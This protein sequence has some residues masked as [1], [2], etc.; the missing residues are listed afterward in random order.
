MS[1]NSSGK[2]KGTRNREYEDKRSKLLTSAGLIFLKEPT[3]KQSLRQI[4]EGV[5]VTIPTLNHYFGGRDGVISAYLEFTWQS[6]HWHLLDAAEPKGDL[7]ACIRLKLENLR[8]AFCHYGLEQLHIFGITEG[9]G[10]SS[11]GP[12]YLN[13]FLEP[14]LQAAE[15][16]MAHYQKKGEISKDIDLRFA[17]LTLYAPLLTL[18]MHQ[19]HLGGKLVRFV[20]IDLFIDG[21]SKNF[22]KYLS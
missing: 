12:A 13:F 18:L 7:G 15:A 10:N 22:L 14:T 2:P 11:L 19:N 6:A 16:W 20:E 4:A 1:K 17:A 3:V 5:G 8:D 21:H 9:L